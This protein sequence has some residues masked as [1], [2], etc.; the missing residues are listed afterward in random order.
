MVLASTHGLT[1]STYAHLEWVRKMHG[2]AAPSLAQPPAALG[3]G[4]PGAATSGLVQSCA[5]PQALSQG[6]KSSD[7]ISDCF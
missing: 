3:L 6:R 7:L 1:V 5:K 2:R 4:L